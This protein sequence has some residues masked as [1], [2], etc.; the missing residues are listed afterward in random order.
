MATAGVCDGKSTPRSPDGAGMPASDPLPPPHIHT[1]LNVRARHNYST[2]LIAR[3]GS[4]VSRRCILATNS[5]TN[6]TYAAQ[7]AEQGLR[8]DTVPVRLS[9]CLSQYGPTAANLLWARRVGDIDR[10]CSSGVGRAVPRCRR[11]CTHVA[12]HRLASSNM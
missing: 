9:V 5:F 8:N 6:N 11:T 1:T 7:Y 10:C 4:P 2:P 12:E 3:T